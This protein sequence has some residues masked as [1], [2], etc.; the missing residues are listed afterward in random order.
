MERKQ[1]NICQYTVGIVVVSNL[2][3]GLVALSQT[4][5][6]VLAGHQGRS[7]PVSLAYH[8]RTQDLRSGRYNGP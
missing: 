3:A 4:R 7:S 8:D 2:S 6:R 1:T 5:Q